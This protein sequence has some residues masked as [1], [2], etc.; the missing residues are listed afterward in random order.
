MVLVSFSLQVLLFFSAIFRK[1]CRSRV[2]SVLLWLAYLSADSVAVYLLGRL[3]LLVG[4]APGHQLVLFWAPFLLL[5]LGGQE[6]ITAFSME[7]CALWKRHL[8]NLAVQVSLAIYVVGKQWRGDKQLVAPT[9]LMFITGTTKYAERIWALWRAQSTTLAARN[10]QQDALV[11]DNWALFF[12]DTYR[13]QKML[14]SIISDKKER[15]FKRVMEVANTGS[16][17]SMDFFM[18]LTHPKYIPH[19]DDEQPRNISFYYKDNELWRQH[20]SSDELVHMVYKLADIHLSMI[21]DRLALLPRAEDALLYKQIVGHVHP[22]SR[23]E[24]SGQ[25]QQFNMIDMGIQETTRGRLERMMRCVDIII[26][27]GCSTEPAVKVSA[28]VKKLLVDKILAQLISDTDPESELDLTR[29]HGQWAQRWVEKR[30]QVHD[31][32]ESNPAHRAL[33]K[34]KIQDSSFLTSASLWHL[35]TDICLDQGYTSVDEATARTCRELSNYVM[36]LIVNYEGLGTVDERQIFVLT[37]SR[38]VEFFVD[39]P[40]DTRNRPGFFQKAA[41]RWELIAT[42]WVEMLCYITMNCGACSL[43]AKQLCD[44]GEFITHVK[45]LLFILDVPCL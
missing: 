35:V 27:G 14:T 13:Y 44:G 19:Y 12:S 2:L 22:E 30:V 42:V 40:K 7:E 36:H 4:D 5:H 23:V 39:G 34:S 11:R 15:N 41:G 32:S 38:M 1:R 21:Y 26:D 24:W 6:T 9:V 18:D 28:E 31:F 3:T 20:G 37:A 8:L 33:V 29:F 43:H 17:L 10:H 45:M 16:L 25:L